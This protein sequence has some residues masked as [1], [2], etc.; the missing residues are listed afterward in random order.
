MI[1]KASGLH[2]AAV[3][4]DSVKARCGM[5]PLLDAGAIFDLRC[6][7]AQWVG[8]G[9]CSDKA[10]EAA[11]Y[12][13]NARVSALDAEDWQAL[14]ADF[15]RLE[16]QVTLTPRRAEQLHLFLV[17]S[18]RASGAR[19]EGGSSTKALSLAPKSDGW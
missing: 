7:M 13:V 2:L 17:S 10:F 19:L 6:C 9:G 18:A 1:D 5:P 15:A 11:D 16:R 3:V 8:E 4:F 14:I 12:L